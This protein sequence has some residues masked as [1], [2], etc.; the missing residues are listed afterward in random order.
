MR[1]NC[2]IVSISPFRIDILLFS[3][4]VLFSTKTTRIESDDKIELR[5][6]LGPLCLPL[7]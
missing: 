2:G 3:E 4:S 1:I 5:E 7:G 6:V